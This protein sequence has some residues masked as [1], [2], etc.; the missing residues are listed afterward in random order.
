M[1]TKLLGIL[2]LAGSSLF[3]RTHF[4]FSVGVGPAFGYGYYAPPPVVM[5]APPPPVRYVVPPYPGPEYTWIGGYWAP[6]GPRWV[7]R[8]GYWGRRPHPRAL[9]VAPRYYR[10]R[11]YPGYWR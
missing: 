9:W 6:A 5:Y 4:S 8:A 2:L 11:W 10:A 7:W 3:A 1:K